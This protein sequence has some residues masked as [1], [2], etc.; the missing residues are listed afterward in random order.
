[1]TAGLRSSPPNAHSVT[2]ACQRGGAAS[3]IA[4]HLLPVSGTMDAERGRS[5]ERRSQ[6][7]DQPQPVPDSRL[8]HYADVHEAR[9]IVLAASPACMELT[10]FS[11]WLARTALSGTP[12]NVTVLAGRRTAASVPDSH[13]CRSV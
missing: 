9:R 7:L 12:A 3:I 13:T 2:N 4:S 10:Q 8:Q 6:R 5:R 11:T 1:V